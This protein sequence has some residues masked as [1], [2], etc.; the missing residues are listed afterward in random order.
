MQSPSKR[1]PP[2]KLSSDLAPS[3][4]DSTCWLRK[5]QACVSFHSP[6]SRPAHDRVEVSL[7]LADWQVTSTYPMTTLSSDGDRKRLWWW[8]KVQRGGIVQD[9]MNGVEADGLFFEMV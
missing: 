9:L 3:A 1:R 2:P 4:R 7:S 8:I 6:R 5:R